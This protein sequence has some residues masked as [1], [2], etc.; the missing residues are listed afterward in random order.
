MSIKG[1]LIF[2]GVII[3]IVL[4]MAVPVITGKPLLITKTTHDTI[5][6]TDTTIALAVSADRARDT[7]I[8]VSC[9][10]K[11]N[12]VHY[13]RPVQWYFEPSNDRL[14]VLTADSPFVYLFSH[15]AAKS[16]LVA[17]EIYLLT[18]EMGDARTENYATH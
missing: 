7:A 13:S 17:R 14:V 2:S 6:V 5:Y 1:A 18:K 3:A 15:P 11:I 16:C 10:G 4:A 8:Y 12:K 9:P